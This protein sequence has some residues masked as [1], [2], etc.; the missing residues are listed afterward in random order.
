M[1]LQPHTR[2]PQSI[3]KTEQ[4]DVKQ[5]W[6]DALVAIEL[7]ITPANFKTWFKDTHIVSLEDGTITLGVPSVFVRDWLSDKFQTMILKVLRELSPHVRSIEYAVVQRSDR[8]HETKQQTV[9]A[10]LP[11]EE[12]YINKSDNLNPKYIFDTFVI[13]PFNALAHTAAK[14]VAEKPG[15]AYNP[16]FIYGKTGH[17]KTHL[18]Q[19]VGNQLK[20]AGKKVFYVTS[21]RFTVDYFNALQ[22]GTANNFKD[23]YRQYDVLIMDDVQ[24]LANK[25]KTQEELFHLFNALHDNNKQIVF[26]SDIHPALLSGLEE[27]LQSRFAQGMIVDIPAPDL[28]SRAAILRA[29]AAQNSINLEESV[30]EH[31]AVTIE[32]NIRE[33]EGALNTIMCQS[34]LMGRTLNLDEVKQIIKNSTRPRKTLAVSDVVDKV[35][36]Y[37]DIDPSSIYEKTRRKE[38]VKP[39]QLIMYILREDFQVSYPARASGVGTTTGETG[40]TL[41][42]SPAT[43]GFFRSPQYYPS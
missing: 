9:N 12:Y 35:A 19:A 38:V 29:K 7:S 27:R 16:L 10:A 32:G 31:L 24:F 8:R 41:V 37:F 42:L 25:E 5:L 11:L 39:R 14:T 13:G 2:D 43:V 4:I 21:E 15:I 40:I 20:R 1:Q 3:I 36:R 22:N 28:E 23:K 17:G 18:I 34:Q 33:L 6:D 26:S 30:V